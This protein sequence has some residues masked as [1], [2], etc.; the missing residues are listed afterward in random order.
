[1]KSVAVPD[2]RTET[3]NPG[4]PFP[5]SKNTNERDEPDGSRLKGSVNSA[6]L[7]E[8]AGGN[9]NEGVSKFSFAAP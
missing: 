4:V 1:M 9:A 6:V 2:P 5:G 3:S 8:D 7:P